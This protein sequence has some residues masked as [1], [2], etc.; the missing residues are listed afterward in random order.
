MAEPGNPAK[1]RGNKEEPTGRSP[2]FSKKGLVILI[3]ALLLEAVTAAFLSRMVSGGSSQ[4][5]DLPDRERQ[6]IKVIE[7]KYID[8]EG[9]TFSVAVA[10]NVYQT[11]RVSKIHVEVDPEL[12]AEDLEN[13]TT[14]IE[15]LGYEIKQSL[16]EII[17]CEGHENLL[18]PRKRQRLQNKLRQEIARMLG[19][20][21]K[22]IR[23]VI[24]DTVQIHG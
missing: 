16:Q 23:A 1:E 11:I 6:R 12:E 5:E 17:E 8:L 20:T 2:M 15:N 24:Y 4:E 10:P 13:L 14:S 3:V 7:K 21:D 9:P 22:E 19:L 18:V